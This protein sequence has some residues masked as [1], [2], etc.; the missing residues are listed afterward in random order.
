MRA[1]P[2]QVVLQAV[3]V[4]IGAALLAAC[5]SGSSPT[6]TTTAEPLVMPLP[7]GDV[8]SE[9]V[10]EGAYRFYPNSARIEPGQPYFFQLYTHCWETMRIDIDGSLWGGTGVVD[11]DGKVPL[12]YDNPYDQ[13][14]V[15][16]DA[17]K[18]D[19]ATYRSDGGD[20]TLVL[21]RL[22]GP[23]EYPICA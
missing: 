9:P 21:V 4:L 3:I 2:G 13:G 16:V 20:M 1:H 17:D 7:S 5:G 8:R 14:L 6:A 12:E 22:S 18:S 19:T 11:H 10:S 15:I 23:R